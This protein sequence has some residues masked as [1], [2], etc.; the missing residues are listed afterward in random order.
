M[1]TSTMIPPNPSATMTTPIAPVAPQ[2]K[3]YPVPAQIQ[4]SFPITTPD[5]LNRSSVEEVAD[6]PHLISHSQ[7][8][9]LQRI[10]TKVQLLPNRFSDPDYPVLSQML[11]LSDWPSSREYSSCCAGRQGFKKCNRWSFCPY[12]CYRKRQN[13]LQTYLRAFLRSSAWQFLTLSF[14]GHLLFAH[15]HNSCL[16]CL[17][18]CGLALRSLVDSGFVRG[19][20]W[21]EEIQVL[22]FL[23]SAVLPH[24]HA[25]LDGDWSEGAE[26]HLLQTLGN[27]RNP[28]DQPLPLLPSLSCQRIPTVHDFCRCLK[29]LFKPLDLVQPYRSAWPTAEA[30]DRGL[31]SRLNRELRDFAEGYNVV[32]YERDRI[33]AKGTLSA[34]NSRFLGVRAAQ[35]DEEREFVRQVEREA[36]EF[37]PG[38]E[39][40]QGV[41]VGE[42]TQVEGIQTS[43]D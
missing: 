13:A 16:D 27:F 7:S 10:S 4:N 8:A 25:V 18:A 1:I 23:P 22:R 38:F 5:Q 12:C 40:E 33:G 42:P 6:H 43:N 11:I 19:A 9:C 15:N 21:V 30:E 41:A 36:A 26:D 29:Y 28:D 14:S 17:N 24:I 3:A 20:H 32:M 34:K 2:F 35:R 31:A 39:S 37:R